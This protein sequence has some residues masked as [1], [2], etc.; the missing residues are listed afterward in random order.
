MQKNVKKSRLGPGFWSARHP[1]AGQNI[2]YSMIQ[3]LFAIEFHFIEI[4]PLGGWK[5]SSIQ[6]IIDIACNLQI[7]K[8][9]KEIK[10]GIG[11]IHQ[12]IFHNK[13]VL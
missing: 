8:I 6:Y 9:I 7:L 5:L 1:N 13:S 12:N 10:I 4:D 2:Q 11:I 3:S